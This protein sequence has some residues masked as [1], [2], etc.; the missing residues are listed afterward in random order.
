M[1]LHALLSLFFLGAHAISG[2]SQP[3]KVEYS[4]RKMLEGNQLKA[5]YDQ[6]TPMQVIDARSRSYFDGTLLPNARWLPAE[7]SDRDILATLPSKGAL[8]VVYC[9]NRQCPASGKLYDRL[10]RLGYTNVYEYQ[11]GLMDWLKRGYRT[12]SQ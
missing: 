1:V 5:L 7:S 9:S 6:K 8:I 3:I 2:A 10:T 4:A 11:E 12:I